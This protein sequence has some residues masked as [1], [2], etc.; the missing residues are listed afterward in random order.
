MKQVSAG[1][2]SKRIAEIKVPTLILWGGHDRLIP[3]AAAKRFSA[4][5]VGSR[6]VI[7]DDL[8][9]VPHEEDPARTLAAA[10]SFLGRDKQGA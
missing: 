3:V 2:I 9:H 10:M 8:G 5:I 7:F 1:V 4:D 6:Q